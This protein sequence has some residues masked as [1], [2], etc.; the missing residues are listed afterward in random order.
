MDTHMARTEAWWHGGARVGKRGRVTLSARVPWLTS[1]LHVPGVTCTAAP[2]WRVFRAPFP[3]TRRCATAVS[4]RG[5]GPGCRTR[6]EG[7][8]LFR[9]WTPPGGSEDCRVQTGSPHGGCVHR[10]SGGRSSGEDTSTPSRQYQAPSTHG[11]RGTPKRN[12]GGR[13]GHRCVV[14]GRYNGHGVG[15]GSTPRRQTRSCWSVSQSIGRVN[16]AVSP[17]SPSCGLAN[18][19]RALG[20]SGCTRPAGP[21]TPITPHHTTVNPPHPS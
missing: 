1:R 20:G 8:T 19:I 9:L 13:H 15:W 21:S 2:T 12:T 6:C 4:D 3:V 7:G 10:G 14:A 18:P 17:R 11:R 16:A 5:T